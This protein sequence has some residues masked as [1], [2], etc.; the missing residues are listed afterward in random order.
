MLRTFLLA[1][2]HDCVL[3]GAHLDYTGSIAV[4]SLL[5]DAAGI[6]P[7]E[8]V[9]VANLSQ[10]QRLFTYAI[11]A[12]PGSG[13]IELNGAAAH[14]G[15]PGDRLILMTYGQLSAPEWLSHRARLVFVDRHNHLVK[16]TAQAVIDPLPPVGAPQRVD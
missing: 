15:R 8:Q 3:T 4:D 14:H 6:L 9:Q 2:I 10:G 13:R 16:V 1:K 12:P 7:G 5:L 11:P